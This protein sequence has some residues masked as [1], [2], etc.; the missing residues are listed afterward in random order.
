MTR[1]GFTVMF[2][3]MSLMDSKYIMVPTSI[4]IAGIVLIIVG[5]SERRSN[6]YRD[7]RRGC[8]D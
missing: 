7:S 3:G 2:I 4:I 1:V 5:S 6:E 8:R